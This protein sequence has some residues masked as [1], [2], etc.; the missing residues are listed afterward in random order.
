MIDPSYMH[1]LDSLVIL[2]ELH[3]PLLTRSGCK[4]KSVYLGPAY[5]SPISSKLGMCWWALLPTYHAIYLERE[6]S[7]TA[8]P[9]IHLDKNFDPL[10]ICR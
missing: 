10:K 2:H 7:Q 3:V 9:L 4:A 8:V 6:A 1:D 5:L